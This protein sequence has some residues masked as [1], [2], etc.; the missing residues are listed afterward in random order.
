MRKAS[1][2]RD[3]VYTVMAIFKAGVIKEL[4]LWTKCETYEELIC[5]M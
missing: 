4:E 2:Q 1:L 3:T 5:H